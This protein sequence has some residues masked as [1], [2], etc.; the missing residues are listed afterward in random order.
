MML[1]LYRAQNTWDLQA[2]GPKINKIAHEQILIFGKM[3][4]KG[5]F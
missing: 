2:I 1:I 3:N 5:Y 4:Y